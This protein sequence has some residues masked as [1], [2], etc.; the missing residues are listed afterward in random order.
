MFTDRLQLSL[1]SEEDTLLN[2]Y[3]ETPR[4]VYSPPIQLIGRIKTTFTEGEDP[5]ESVQ[6]KAVITIPTKQLITKS[7]PHQTES[8][9]ETLRKAKFSYDGFEYLVDKVT[10]KTLVADKWQMYEFGCSVDKKS[11]LGGV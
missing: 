8:D 11:S 6:T 2:V 4:K 1:L 3:D 5:I 7:V 9:L 10:P